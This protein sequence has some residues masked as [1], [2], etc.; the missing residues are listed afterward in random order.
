MKDELGPFS[1]RPF[2]A[3]HLLPSVQQRHSA[4][5][6][7][8]NIRIKQSAQTLIQVSRG[9][10]VAL[11]HKPRPSWK[12][13]AARIPSV[14]VFH[15]PGNTDHSQMNF[16]HHPVPQACHW[17]SWRAKWPGPHKGTAGTSTQRGHEPDTQGPDFVDTALTPDTRPLVIALAG[18]PTSCI[19]RLNTRMQKTTLRKQYPLL[20]S[21]P[22][23]TLQANWTPQ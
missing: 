5:S 1:H 14:P 13:L 19:G 2:T 12:D 7:R 8:P 15:S 22:T 16:S 21:L 4:Q 18:T 17:R 6:D 10:S 9:A 23:P 3:S 20:H 11:G